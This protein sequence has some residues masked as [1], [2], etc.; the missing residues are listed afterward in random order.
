MI[1][2]RQLKNVHIEY[3]LA[4]RNDDYPPFASW[5]ELEGIMLSEVSR[6]EDSHIVSLIQGI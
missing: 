5:M 4:I 6:L 3:H 1:Q 2:S